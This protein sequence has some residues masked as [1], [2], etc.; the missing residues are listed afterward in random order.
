MVPGGLRIGQAIGHHQVHDPVRDP[1]HH[2]PV[3]HGLPP[4]DGRPHLHEG[5]AALRRGRRLFRQGRGKSDPDCVWTE[6][7]EGIELVERK[8]SRKEGTL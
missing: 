8:D 2:L 1:L 7:E 5:G 6:T 3:R 4:H